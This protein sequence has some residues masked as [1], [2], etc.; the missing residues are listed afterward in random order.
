M[1]GF[2]IG[3]RS[4]EFGEASGTVALSVQVLNGTIREGDTISIRLTTADDSAHGR[5]IMLAITNIYLPHLIIKFLQLLLTM[6]LFL[7]F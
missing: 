3:S 6:L 5:I 1:I 7:K 2:S 4:L